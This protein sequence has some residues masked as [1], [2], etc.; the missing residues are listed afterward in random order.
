MASKKILVAVDVS[1]WASKTVSYVG[2]LVEK[3]DVAIT[4]FHVMTPFPE[5]FWDVE[6][7]PALVYRSSDMHVWDVA[8][9]KAVEAEMEKLS[10][11]LTQRGVPRDRIHIVVQPRQMGIARDILCETQKGYD[12]LIVG[13]RGASKLKE[14]IMGSTASK[15]LSRLTSVPLWVVGEDPQGQDILIGVDASEESLKAVRYIAAIIEGQDRTVHLIHVVRALEL[16]TRTYDLFFTP[17]ERLEGMRRVEQQQMEE[18]RA[19]MGGFFEEAIDIFEH[20]GIKRKRVHHEIMTG[21]FSRA[22]TLIEEAR[23]RRCGTIVVGRRGLSRVEEFF[24]GRVSSKLL[25]MGYDKTVCI[26][27]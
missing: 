14:I 21:S 1:E 6:A 17:D 20:S 3:G 25:Q 18:V 10:T 12:A 7:S 8:Q 27:S 4:I 19:K 9:R 16:L 23:S 13:R 11:M 2:S 5:N 22:A 24:L 15:L 26:V